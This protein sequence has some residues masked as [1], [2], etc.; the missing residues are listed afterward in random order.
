MAGGVIVLN[1]SSFITVA[2][3]FCRYIRHDRENG[4]EVWRLRSLILPQGG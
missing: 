3:P 4:I 1:L 2:L